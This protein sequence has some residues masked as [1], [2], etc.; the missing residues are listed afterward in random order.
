MRPHEKIRT[1]YPQ[2]QGSNGITQIHLQ[3]TVRPVCVCVCEITR[4]S[5]FN[6]HKNHHALSVVV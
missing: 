5:H 2:Y 3:M 4:S 1:S 6:N